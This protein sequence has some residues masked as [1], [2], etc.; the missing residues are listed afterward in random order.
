MNINITIRY[1]YLY[2]LY[3]LYKT[4]INIQMCLSISQTYLFFLLTAF[5]LA[6]GALP[7]PSQLVIISLNSGNS[8]MSFSLGKFCSS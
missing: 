5:P 8:D 7:V 3:I 2:I 6:G 4:Q 1:F